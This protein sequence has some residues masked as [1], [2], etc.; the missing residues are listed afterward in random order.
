M[1]NQPPE[2]P[3]FSLAEAEKQAVDVLTPELKDHLDLTEFAFN[4]I[5]GV[6]TAAPRLPLP[7]VTQAR[8]VCTTLLVRASNDLRCAALLAVRGYAIQAVSTVASMYEVTFTLA[9]I[10][11]DETLAQTWIDHD[12]PTRPFMPIK[13]LTKLALTKL[14]IPDPA[15]H[16]ERQYLTYRQL[17][18]AKHAN[19]LFQTQHGQQRRGNV[20]FSQNGPDL[21]E[22]AL[23]AAWFALE[24]AAGLASVAAGS[25]LANHV[26]R[27]EAVALRSEVTNLNK[28]VVFELRRRAV[29]RWGS[30]DPLPGKWKL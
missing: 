9:A 12:D 21:S 28:R 18:M 8:K 7:R 27:S 5:R 20:M 22:P 15:T 17:C 2:H 19:P 6:Q 24:H 14:G 26:P 11:D 4:L 25:F 10:G 23:R 3:C 1:S 29:A 13:P 16:T 30:E